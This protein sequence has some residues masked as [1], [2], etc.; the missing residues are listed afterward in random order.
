MK[1]LAEREEKERVERKRPR[2]G[3]EEV[4]G[5]RRSVKEEC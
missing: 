4:C 3:E 5:E 1:E 2:E